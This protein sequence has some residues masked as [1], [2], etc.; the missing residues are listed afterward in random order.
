MLLV[1]LLQFLGVGAQIDSWRAPVRIEALQF[2][3]AVV[4]PAVVVEGELPKVQ[5][6]EKGVL[7]DFVVEKGDLPVSQIRY[8]LAKCFSVSINEHSTVVHR[9]FMSPTKHSSECA[10]FELT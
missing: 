4:L 8:Y 9:Q 2:I 3:G 7:F 6:F 1:I 10:I 5:L